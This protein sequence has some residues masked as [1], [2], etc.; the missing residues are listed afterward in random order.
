MTEIPSLHTER[1]ILRPFS[2]TDAPD[3]KR[4]AGDPAIAD[5]TLNIPHPYEDGVAE[6][7]IDTHQHLF[8]G[9]RGVTFAIA[10]QTSATLV[11]A[12]SLRTIP[13]FKRAELG[14]W[15]G[16]PYWGNGYCSEA[17]Q[18]IIAF[19][20]CELNLNRVMAYH[21]TRNPASGRVMEKVGMTY[22][23]HLRQHVYKADASGK[24]GVYEDLRLYAILRD[25]FR[26]DCA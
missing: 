22:E 18:A 9:G 1:L 16:K 19:A 15:I 8:R 13:R 25:D 11:G 5:T 7:W 17:A 3:V 14:Y 10:L 4:L 20:F 26:Q 2:P 24:N 6:A 12:I 23:G 21:L